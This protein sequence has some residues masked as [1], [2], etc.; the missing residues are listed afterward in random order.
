[1]VT[2]MRSGSSNIGRGVKCPRC[3]RPITRLVSIIS[4]GGKGPKRARAEPCGHVLINGK[5]GLED[6]AKVVK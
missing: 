5:D 4:M 6:V 3:D 2:Y 1:M